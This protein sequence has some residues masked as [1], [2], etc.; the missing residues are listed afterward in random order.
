[1]TELILNRYQI[2][3]VIMAAEERVNFVRPRKHTASLLK[4]TVDLY[5]I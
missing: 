4:K 3:G 1:M 2:W 5:E